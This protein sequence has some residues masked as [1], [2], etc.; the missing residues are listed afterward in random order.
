MKQLSKKQK[1]D[2]TAFLTTPDY[3]LPKQILSK[4]GPITAVY[5]IILIEK[6]NFD[7]V[8]FT[9]QEMADAVGVG[10]NRIKTA[11]KQLK[12]AKLI[13]IALRGNPSKHWHTVNANKLLEFSC[14]NK[15]E[16]SNGTN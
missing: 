2:L 10:P 12:D 5:L 8:K 15:M 9:N 6:S 7:W 3:K 13:T 1:S 16:V 11:K 4:F 14:D